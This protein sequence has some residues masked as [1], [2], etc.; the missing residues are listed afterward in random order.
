MAMRPVLKALKKEINDNY[1]SNLLSE[2]TDKFYR[3]QSGS[4]Y[5]RYKQTALRKWWRENSIKLKPIEI[6]VGTRIVHK[7]SSGTS[8]STIIKNCK[9]IGLIDY[10]GHKLLLDT[11]AVLSDY[12]KENNFSMIWDKSDKINLTDLP[13]ELLEKIHSAIIH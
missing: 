7:S 6:P 9:A 8:Y 2:Q 5:S 13:T 1:L 4:A 11:T 3:L 12:C 10:C